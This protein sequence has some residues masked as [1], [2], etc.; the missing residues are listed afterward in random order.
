M[1]KIEKIFEYSL[2]N[3]QFEPFE[4]KGSEEHALKPGY[5]CR[6]YKMCSSKTSLRVGYLQYNSGKFCLTFT[7]TR[8]ED[9]PNIKFVKNTIS[10]ITS[11]PIVNSKNKNGV[12]MKYT[13]EVEVSKNKSTD[14]LF[15]T[16]ESLLNFFEE[17][18]N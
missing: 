18:D 7:S 5:N 6:Y 8:R 9:I 15:L 1:E 17:R 11:N 2:D 10:E 12:D 13:W 14:E 4:K 16:Q 3:S